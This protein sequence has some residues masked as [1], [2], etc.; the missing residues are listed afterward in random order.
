M[1]TGITPTPT[2]NGYWLTDSEGSVYIFG[3][4]AY[5]GSM[6]GLALNKPVVGIA[7]TPTG[8]GYWLVAADGGIFTFGD[9]GFFGSMGGQ[10]LNRP[11]V[12]MAA[13]PNG[14]GYWLVAADGGVFSFGNAAFFGSMGGQ[15]LNQ[16]VVGMAATPNGQG[17]WLT[18]GDGGVF[19]FGN[20]GFFGT[21]VGQTL[22]RPIVGIAGTPDGQGYWLTAG[23]GGVFTFGNAGYFG[24]MGG[25]YIYKPVV[26]IAPTRTGQG[27]WLAAADGGVFTFGDGQFWG[28][29]WLQPRE[30]RTC[31]I[32]CRLRNTNG[33]LTSFMAPPQFYQSFFFGRLAG[34]SLFDYFFDITHG[35]VNLVGD[36][37]GWLD[38]GHTIDEHD[39]VMFQ[40]QRIQAFNW[41]MQA[42]RDAGFAVDGYTRQVVIINRDTDWGG[43][44]IG[45]SM[46]LPHT[47]TTTWSHSRAA[48]EFGHV[49]GLDDSFNTDGINSTRYLDQH[50]IM[51]YATRGARFMMTFQGLSMD[52]GPILNGAYIDK[53]QGIPPSR[54]F[55]VPANLAANYVTLAPLGH[56]D[57]PGFLLVC[58]PPNATRTNT[59]WVELHDKS[60]WD[61][62]I[63]NSR[64]AIHET[65][66]G[67]GGAYVLEMGGRQSLNSSNDPAILIPDGSIGISYIR[68]NGK[69]VTVRIWELV[70]AAPGNV[71]IMSVV[72][73]PPGDDVAGEHVIIRNNR[74]NSV[75]LG[76]WLLRDDVNHPV[77]GPWQFVFPNI[78]LLPGE[79]ITV[80]TKNGTNDSRNLFWNL[81]RAIW[82]N[83]GDAAVLEDNTGVEVS[84]FVY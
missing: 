36:V 48:H 3:D 40:A 30:E 24:S 37:F 81:N 72:F 65:R 73:N 39:A 75:S 44:S 31:V 42:A 47:P 59:Y 46:L 43:V 60:N 49:L 71:E 50:C 12:E 63:P 15:P 20:A 22:N 79:D 4:A 74:L 61:R 41:G 77:K 78:T 64:I 56:A 80:W 62:A 83:T 27:Y 21:T 14:Q 6:T 32:L 29:H 5:F 26:G 69:R 17:Y 52:A 19:T 54:V 38:I 7:S 25:Q 33:S 70:P 34:G 55:T 1:H 28:S 57:E 84:R 11:V 8:Q 66:P 18:A 9:A 13:T 16:P 68:Q 2:G 10:A 58:I 51:S 76:N 23:D 45:R 67:D 82:N 53:L 35:R